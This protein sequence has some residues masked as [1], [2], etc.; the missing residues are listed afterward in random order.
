MSHAVKMGSFANA[1][2]GDV[3]MKE[4][5]WVYGDL[6]GWPMQAPL[7]QWQTLAFL[8]GNDICVFPAWQQCDGCVRVTPHRV[9]EKQRAAAS[10]PHVPAFFTCIVFDFSWFVSCISEVLSSWRLGS[11]FKLAVNNVDSALNF[12]T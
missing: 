6:D 11:K 2:N 12:E 4:F 5:L 9:R 7:L 10:D 8:E 1:G 3:M